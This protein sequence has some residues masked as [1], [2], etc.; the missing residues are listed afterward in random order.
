MSFKMFDPVTSD[1]VYLYV[2]IVCKWHEWLT[3]KQFRGRLTIHL[4][5]IPLVYKKDPPFTNL[6][7]L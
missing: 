2:Y 5:L 1:D 4:E 3:V 6:F 7:L